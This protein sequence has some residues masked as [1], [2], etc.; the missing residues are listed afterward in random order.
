VAACGSEEANDIA[1]QAVAAEI[2][3]L[4]F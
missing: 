3:C 2:D 1:P 4:T